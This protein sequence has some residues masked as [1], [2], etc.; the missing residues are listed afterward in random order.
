MFGRHSFL[1][2]ICFALFSAQGLVAQAP[3]REIAITIDDLPSNSVGLSGKDTLAM[4]AKLVAALK[5]KQVPAVGFVNEKKLYV[6]GEVDERI[7]ALRTWLDQG[8]ELGNHTF[9]HMSLSQATLKDWEDDVVRGET[10]TGMLMSERKMKLR[11]LR[12]PFL[13]VGRDIET[14]RAAD[15]FLTQ[16][17]YRIAP[18]TMDAW[19]WMY[20]VGYDIARRKADTAQQQKL[21]ASYLDY[22]NQVFDYSEKLSKNLLGYEPKQ[23]LLLHCNWLEADHIGDLIETL[24]KRGYK[25]VSLEDALTDEAYSMPDNFV[26]E[27]GTTWIDHW[28]VTRGTPPQNAPVFPQWVIDLSQGVPRMDQPPL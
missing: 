6:K 27:D 10:V 21:V 22:T 8:F 24:R 18:I 9:S 16:R 15:L 13:A 25:F 12:H 28:A 26:G 14:R 2:A 19:D 20:S 4:N 3:Q 1:I 11:Y 17:G 7:E 5:E 23:I